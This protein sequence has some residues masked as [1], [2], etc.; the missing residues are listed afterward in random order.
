MNM[1]LINP[2]FLYK[3]KLELLV[4]YISINGLLKSFS[5][6]TLCVESRLVSKSTE[7]ILACINEYPGIRYRELFR[8]TGLSNGVLSFHLK[9]F[10][11]SKMVNA[12]KLGYKVTRYYP[13]AV[14]ANGSNILD[15][16]LN[17]TRRKIILFL[18]EHS[19][20][21]FKEIVHYIDRSRST[22]SIQ[23]QHLERP[24]ISLN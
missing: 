19:K 10:R 8:L 9:K 17:S 16:L 6:R 2:F 3:T 15:H 24:K 4:L 13:K 22:T 11:K 21:R 5:N 7:K 12:K 1:V 18:F 20:C 23:L 14:K